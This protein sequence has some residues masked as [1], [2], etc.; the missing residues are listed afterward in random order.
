MA[1]LM[2][3]E[4]F[5]GEFNRLFNTLFD[6][7][8]VHG[9]RWS[10]AMDLVEAEDHFLLKADLPGLGEEDISIEIEDN[11]LT[12]SGE[13]RAEAET[14]ERGWYR[15]ERAFGRFSRSLTLPE[16]VDAEGVSAAFDKGVLEV[17]IPKPE[18][19][20]PRRVQIG[21]GNGNSTP[22]DLEGTAE[23]Q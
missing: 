4:P 14:T 19:R 8:Q 6:A 23:E 15:V 17:R 10:P 22:A 21:V 9:Q 7:S 16:G 5:A 12:L 13:R 18:E 11:T 20:K 3:P 2:K 1:L